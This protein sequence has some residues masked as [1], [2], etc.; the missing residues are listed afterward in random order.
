MMGHLTT[1]EDL[2]KPQTRSRR[3]SSVLSV[4]SIA[5]ILT[6]AMVLGSGSL[7]TAAE[8]PDQVIDPRPDSRVTTST[9]V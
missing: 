5:L 8:P 3:H 1:Q 4:T 7:A 6:F 9:C 2:M